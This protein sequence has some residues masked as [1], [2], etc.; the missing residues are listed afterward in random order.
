MPPA[1]R[2][3][4]FFAAWSGRARSLF[5]ERFVDLPTATG[6]KRVRC[7]EPAGARSAAAPLV[8]FVHGMSLLA[9]RDPRQDAFCE[10]LAVAGFRV[11]APRVDEVAELRFGSGSVDEIEAAVRAAIVHP[12]LGAPGEAAVASVS[13][14]AAA[15]LIAAA[16]PALRDRVRGALVLGGY[17]D[18]RLCVRQLLTTAEDDY[19]RL[20]GLKNFLRFAAEGTP[21]MDAALLAMCQDNVAGRPAST[22]A[23]RL[24]GL[25]ER[26]ARVLGE[27]LASA[28]ARAALLDRAWAKTPEL[29]DLL[30]LE[31][32]IPAIAFPI[33]IVHGA[34]D[35]VID[36]EQA[37]LLAAWLR[38][39]GCAHR[40]CVTP[41]IDHGTR[42]GLFDEGLAAVDVGRTV[43]SFMEAALTAR[44]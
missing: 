38:A 13:F 29:W 18:V 37:H 33:A 35:A 26:D 41:L 12:D 34:G 9:E 30:D 32:A 1:I 39:S 16:R 23:E 21:A 6:V 43:S 8:V 19:G 14:S 40:L 2:L 24:V 25:P 15:T 31:P 3:A 11:L 27:L 5:R 42:K 22:R 17:A 7:T 4:L 44:R 36:V 20:L 28:A 10:A